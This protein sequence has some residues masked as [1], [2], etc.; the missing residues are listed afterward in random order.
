MPAHRNRASIWKVVVEPHTALWTAPSKTIKTPMERKSA[1]LAT[2]TRRLSQP[3]SGKNRLH[4]TQAPRHSPA[5]VDWATCNVAARP[6]LLGRHWPLHSGLQGTSR[7]PPQVVLQ[8]S[9]TT[10]LARPTL[11][12]IAEN[13]PLATRGAGHFMPTRRSSPISKTVVANPV[14]C[15]HSWAMMR[16]AA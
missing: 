12:C 4:S 16:T 15:L 2:V 13:K 8:A 14:A 10:R 3:L 1:G 9:S 5:V 11:W 6:L 7:S